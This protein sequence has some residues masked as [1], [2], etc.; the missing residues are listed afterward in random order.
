MQPIS[1]SD[2]RDSGIAPG[3]S[4]YTED[5]GEEEIFGSV[6]YPNA[7][8][9]ARKT[10]ILSDGPALPPRN[11]KQLSASSNEECDPTTF[12]QNSTILR[13]KDES[14]S[15]VDPCDNI[16]ASLLLA[17]TNGPN[18]CCDITEADAVYPDPTSPLSYPHLSEINHMGR[19]TLTSRKAVKTIHEFVYERHV[20]A[21]N[22]RSGASRASIFNPLMRPNYTN[23]MAQGAV[24]SNRD[25]EHQRRQRLRNAINSQS[26]ASQTSSCEDKGSAK[27]ITS[28]LY[29]SGDSRYP[30]N[31]N[32]HTPNIKPALHPI[33]SYTPPS[34][35]SKDEP[36]PYENDYDEFNPDVGERIDPCI[37]PPAPPHA[38]SPRTRI[39][40][41]VAVEHST[42]I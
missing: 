14:K 3:D 20:A 16:R 22:Q 39:H 21:Q 37:S 29:P 23:N 2:S 4:N 8:L 32:I 1:R 10:Q 40:R 19:R 28:S 7:P 26:S 33:T 9:P 18:Q 17:M 41:Q 27:K 38:R 11:F 31:S 35:S 36:S 24:E 34:A 25:S 6:D 5:N 15:N 12:K 42:L 30:A 13:H